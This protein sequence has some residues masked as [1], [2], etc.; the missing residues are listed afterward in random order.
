MIS[1]QKAKL[2]RSKELGLAGLLVQI[3]W[4]GFLFCFGFCCF[5]LTGK[6][7]TNKAH[8]GFFC[9]GPLPLQFAITVT[10]E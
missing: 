1:V 2:F 6:L 9:L 10:G 8:L 7:P 3:M 4:V 5:F